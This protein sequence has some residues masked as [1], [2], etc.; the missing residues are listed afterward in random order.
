MSTHRETS[1][2]AERDPD[3]VGV[4]AAMHRA[5]RRARQ[6]TQMAART[7][8]GEQLLERPPGS[9]GTP[10][11]RDAR[12]LSF[13]QVQGYEDVPGPL[14][15]E[16]L[17]RDAR[18]Q[19]WNLLFAHIS[20]S[21][22]T[23]ELD[24]LDGGSWVSGPWGEILKAKHLGFDGGALDEWDPEFS[25][26]RR[27]LRDYVE[28][29]EF[30]KVFDLIEF[31]L[32]RPE[33]PRAFITQMKAT[34][35]ACRL[36]YT[37]DVGRP[38]TV[39]PAVTPEA[40]TAFVESLRELREAGLDSSAAQLRKA[41]GCINAGD[42]GG[43]I[44][45]SIHAVVSVARWVAPGSKELKPALD[46]LARQ[47]ALHPALRK[48]LIALYGYTSDEQGIRHELLDQTETQAGQDEAVFM[49][50]ACASFA[51]FLWRKHK[52]GESR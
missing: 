32:R 16:E 44:R 11:R 52:A 23:G 12:E 19:I 13:S 29:Q 9:R 38:Q 20:R 15:L 22:T 46:S 28:N 21:R 7:A 37:I 14:K 41:S 3:M 51:S 26:I 25:R 6:R 40:G 30:N 35:A 5:A 31:V 42:W 50:G 49:L 33:C 47:G 2:D 45:E 4:E 34:F 8:D 43:S 1:P 27:S 39:I 36:A 10:T 48:G 24:V 18:T 17:P